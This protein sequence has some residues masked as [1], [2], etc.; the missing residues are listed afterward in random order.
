MYTFREKKA[1]V[2]LK[3]GTGQSFGD[4]LFFMLEGGKDSGT[5]RSDLTAR[6]RRFES[7]RIGGA[8]QQD[9]TPCKSI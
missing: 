9:R 7:V 2:A 1:D 4:V 8:A 3:P 5:S 6:L